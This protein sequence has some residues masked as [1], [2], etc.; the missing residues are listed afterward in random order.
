MRFYS[1]FHYIDG[2]VTQTVAINGK[3]VQSGIHVCPLDNSLLIKWTL[4]RLGYM[5]SWKRE[6]SCVFV[7]WQLSTDH[8]VTS[9]QINTLDIY[10]KR[11]SSSSPC[12][13]TTL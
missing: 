9:I 2:F 11:A 13:F 5:V 8:H 3:L 7:N 4:D 12:T 1:I 6:R 10:W